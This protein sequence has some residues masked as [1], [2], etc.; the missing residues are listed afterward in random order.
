MHAVPV[1]FDIDGL[2]RYEFK[3]VGFSNTWT[4]GMTKA[5]GVLVG[6][7]HKKIVDFLGAVVG[8]ALVYLIH[9]EVLRTRAFTHVFRGL[10]DDLREV[11]VTSGIYPDQ[12]VIQ[13]ADSMQGALERVK[14]ITR[15]ARMSLR[16]L[17]EDS[18]VA[19]AFEQFESE[20]TELQ[21]A[22]YRFRLVAIGADGVAERSWEQQ[23]RAGRLAFQEAAA[24]IDDISADDIDP[25]LLELALS[26]VRSADEKKLSSMH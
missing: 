9:N 2:A 24:R 22:I 14:Q 16:E 4:A 21:G 25:E 11:I 13:Q 10:R 18:R 12:K 8:S 23:V 7:S 20:L 1:G 15:D 19:F 5:F 6:I 26:A 17:N 3:R